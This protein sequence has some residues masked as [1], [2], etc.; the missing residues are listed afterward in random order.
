MANANIPLMPIQGL[1]DTGNI[2][3]QIG[4]Q[5]NNNLRQNRLFQA[6]QKQQDIENTRNNALFEAKLTGANLANERAQKQFDFETGNFLLNQAKSLR[7]MDMPNRA[8]ALGDLQ[9]RLLE[10]G[11]TEQDINDG[12]D[13]GE[14]DFAIQALSIFDNS[15]QGQSLEQRQFNDLNKIIQPALDENGQFNPN[16]ATAEQKAA[17]VKLRIMPPA[18]GSAAITTATTPGLTDTVANSEA[19]ITGKKKRAELMQEL[20]IKPSIQAKVEEAVSAVQTATTRS[21]E[22]RSDEK[23]FSTYET[24]IGGLM[25]ALGETST[26]PIVGFLPAL[27]ANQQI[28]DGAVAAM[29]PVLKGIFRSAGEGTFTD[30]DAKRLLAMLPDRSTAP[31]ARAYQ[32]GMVDSIVRSKL[33]K[34]VMVGSSVLGREVSMGE[35]FQEAVD[36][37]MTVEEVKQ[38]LGIE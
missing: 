12:L 8:R 1:R 19:A 6:Q 24:A 15:T 13:D 18:T 10:L 28:A 33:G 31:E 5:V 38:E 4:G 29:E 26:G 3:T 20:D 21:N 11:F 34:P 36:N 30:A 14:L 27:T 35:V 37:N 2:I 32:L 25:S 22:K 23:A 16:I 17:A 7:Q 9:P